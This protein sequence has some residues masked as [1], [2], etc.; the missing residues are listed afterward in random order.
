MASGICV[1]EK[2]PR[3][4]MN[5]SSIPPVAAGQ[6]TANCP[7]ETMYVAKSASAA[8]KKTA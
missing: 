1:M 3:N 6:A 2:M 5:D 7:A 8:A 4:L